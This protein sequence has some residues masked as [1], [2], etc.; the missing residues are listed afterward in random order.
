MAYAPSRWGTLD[1]DTLASRLEPVSLDAGQLEYL[2]GIE[3]RV[4]GV[5]VAYRLHVD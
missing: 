5:L 1:P 3:K 4:G 2:R